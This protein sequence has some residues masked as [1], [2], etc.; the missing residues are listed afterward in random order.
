MYH[1]V[2][3]T[4]ITDSESMRYVRTYIYIEDVTLEFML[5]DN[6]VDMNLELVFPLP[7]PSNK[8]VDLTVVASLY[9]S[10]HHSQIHAL[11][12]RRML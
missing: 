2:P 6:H 10:Y 8:F 9:G 3:L 4:V 12:V 1:T 11:T 5:L 7:P